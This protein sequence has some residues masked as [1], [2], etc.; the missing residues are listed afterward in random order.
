MRVASEKGIGSTFFFT[1]P[2]EGMKETFV[3]PESEKTAVPVLDKPVIL[4][5]EDDESNR[6][7]LEKILTKI[8]VKI[9]SATDGI[10]AIEQCR[11]HPEITLILMDLQLPVMDGFEATRE[12]KTFRKD[13]SI[14][15]LT[16]FAMSGDKKRALQV[17]C[18]DYL[19][20]PV[21][22]EVLLDT[23]KKYG[24]RV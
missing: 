10:E 18:N 9:L 5:A 7:Y 15:A 13:L 20:K 14:I 11:D 19:S 12:I 1:I 2:H 17:G 3:K 16:A 22:R 21:T 24:V 4:I 8:N 23:L 6:F